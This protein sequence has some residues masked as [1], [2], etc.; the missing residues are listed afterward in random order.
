MRIARL[1]LISMAMLS[2]L[3]IVA[4]AGNQRQSAGPVA[5]GPEAAAGEEG[6]AFTLYV[7]N[8]CPTVSPVDIRVWID[9]EIVVDEQFEVGN[10]HV[11]KKFE[12]RLPEGEHT[13]RAG[14]TSGE[15]DFEKTFEVVGDLWATVGYWYYSEEHYNPTPRQFSFATSEE[16]INFQ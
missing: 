11:W 15:A 6:F 12:L 8:Q 4:C 5:S 14:S 9:E 16:P 2:I 13:L 10:Q 1:V 3:C 7:S